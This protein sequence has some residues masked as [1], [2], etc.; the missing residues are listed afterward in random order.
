ME[1]LAQT[2]ANSLRRGEI[3]AHE[4]RTS[5]AGGQPYRGGA[6]N[7]SV[8]SDWSPNRRRRGHDAAAAFDFR[9]I[10]QANGRSF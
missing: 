9:R 8:A 10:S 2:S 7:I 4:D 1:L 6:D 5:G 3:E